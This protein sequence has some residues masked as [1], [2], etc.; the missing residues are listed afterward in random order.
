MNFQNNYSDMKKP[1]LYWQILIA[2]VLAI[3]YGLFFKNHVEY[4][5]WM[6][7][8]FL[9]GLKMVIIP[10]ILSS[11]ISGVANI[12]EAKNLGRLGME[13]FWILPFYQ[14]SCIGYWIDFRKPV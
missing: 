1:A 3:V 10:L 11:I 6:G 4:V 7:T 9:K 13:N 2:F 8:L 14:Y 12:G 5:S